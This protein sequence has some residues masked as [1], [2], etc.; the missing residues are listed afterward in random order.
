MKKE[1]PEPEKTPR[2]PQPEQPKSV[3]FADEQGELQAWD[4]YWEDMLLIS[5]GPR[6]WNIGCA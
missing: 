2:E 1:A 6:G 4:D 5:R 3:T